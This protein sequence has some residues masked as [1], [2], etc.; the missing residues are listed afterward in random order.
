METNK[1][2]I[3]HTT[4]PENPEKAT[5]A[6]VM[7]TALQATDIEVTM[8]LQ[9][10]SV[11]LAKLGEAEKVAAPG[12]MP[13]KKLLDTFIEMNGKIMICSPCI[14]ERGINPSELVPGGQIVAAGSVVDEIL[15]SQKIL[16][17]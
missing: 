6:F 14:K 15:S 3:I 1:V 12:L 5:L 7:A 8:V 10:N 13:L 17:Y 4:G 9:S 11:W 2:L 16:S